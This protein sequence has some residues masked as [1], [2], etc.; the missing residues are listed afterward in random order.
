MVR[1]FSA[2]ISMRN[3]L[4]LLELAFEP[5]IKYCISVS[6]IAMFFKKLPK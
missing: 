3:K 5:L 1:K 4:I 6:K 2:L